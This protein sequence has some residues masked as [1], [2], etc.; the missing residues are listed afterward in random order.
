[1]SGFVKLRGNCYKGKGS[2]KQRQAFRGEGWGEEARRSMVAMHRGYSF[3]LAETSTQ[4][5]GLRRK[6][7]LKSPSAMLIN[8]TV[9]LTR[10]EGG[11]C[12]HS[13]TFWKS[14]LWRLFF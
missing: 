10:K 4:L 5:R 3:N 7:K 2:A 11:L 6:T 13:F 12:L 8:K 14:K 1:M 9:H